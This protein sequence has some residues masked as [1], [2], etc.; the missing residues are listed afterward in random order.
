MLH[1]K[2]DPDGVPVCRNKLTPLM[3]AA[4]R[5]HVTIVR[6]LLEA[7]ADTSRDCRGRTALSV[8]TNSGFDQ[9]VQALTAV[10][11]SKT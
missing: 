11:V 10:E 6:R 9:V 8:A 3:L 5:G 1:C 2:A 7:R 4:S